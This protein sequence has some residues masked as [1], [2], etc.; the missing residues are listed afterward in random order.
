ML[1]SAAML[2]LSRL[3][4]RGVA[5]AMLDDPLG[6]SL[7]FADTTITQEI[8]ALQRLDAHLNYEPHNSRLSINEIAAI[9]VA[10]DPAWAGSMT[11]EE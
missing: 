4:M 10:A 5:V 7:N 9:S 3:N 6:P 11:K 1:D 8:E 2:V